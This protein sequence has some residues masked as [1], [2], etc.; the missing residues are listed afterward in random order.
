MPTEPFLGPTLN[1]LFSQRNS[2]SQPPTEVV[3][4]KAPFYV[5]GHTLGRRDEEAWPAQVMKLINSNGTHYT[6]EPGPRTRS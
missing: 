5:Q 1:T 3:V 2:A 6:K 4:C